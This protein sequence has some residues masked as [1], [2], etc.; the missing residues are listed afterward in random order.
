MGDLTL[1]QGKWQLM[2]LGAFGALGVTNVAM[3]SE[4]AT[5][6]KTDQEALHAIG[7]MRRAASGERAWDIVGTAL[8]ALRVLRLVGRAAVAYGDSKRDGRGHACEGE[9]CD[10][11][12]L[13]HG[14]GTSGT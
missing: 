10:R 14:K 11:W 8:D 7:V 4:L 9:G 2:Y 1:E 6:T 12:D 3:A 13:H 5:L